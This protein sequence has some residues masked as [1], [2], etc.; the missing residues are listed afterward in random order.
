VPRP[1]A[2]GSIQGKASA[3]DR[4]SLGPQ[5]VEERAVVAGRLLNLRDPE[6]I[7][8]DARCRSCQHRGV[9]LIKGRFRCNTCGGIDVEWAL[10]VD[11]RAHA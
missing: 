11:W 3:I 5:L 4:S 8:L 2:G 1:G 10:R 6:P 7:T 9:E